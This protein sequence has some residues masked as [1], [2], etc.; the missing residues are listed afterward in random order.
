MRGIVVC[1]VGM[2]SMISLC[3]TSVQADD[4]RVPEGC[5]AISKT[6]APS[7]KYFGDIEVVACLG[8]A[9]PTGVTVS[10]E[11]RV[12]VNFPRWG[13]KVEFTVAEIKDGKPV[14]YPDAGINKPDT[15]KASG[16]LIS[17]Q[18]V[19]VDPKNRLWLLDTGRIQWA[20][21]VPGGPKLV[22]VDLKTNKVF[23]KIAIPS[24]VALKTT[25]LND[26]RFDLSRGKGGMAFITDSSRSEPGII[27]VDLESGKSWR[28]LSNH[29]STRPAAKF[30]PILEGRPLMFRRPGQT[31]AYFRVGSDGI[32]IGP[33]GKRLFYCPLSSYRLY[34][35]SVD[36]LADP[37]LSAEETA[38]TVK[39]LGDK[40][41]AVDGMETDSEGNIYLTAYAYNAIIRRSPDGAFRTLA[42]DPRILWPDTLS[43]ATDG[44]LYFT[45]NQLH[46]QAVFHGGK[47]L[48]EKPYLILRL[49]VDKKPVLLK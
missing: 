46:R 35:V 6:G 26:V 32:A 10:H 31:P 20:D 17:V 27:V 25:Y 38:K 15:D 43:L 4:P 37:K 14:P 44:Y 41:A 21:P 7:T 5:E 12:F 9:M 16:S 30:I 24:E 1:L 23:K 3:L 34:E 40:T 45:A 8:G 18:S 11:G 2:I 49:K 33:K 36:A 29:P 42:C 28:R 13:D 22:G 47:D 19:V 48:R 39:D